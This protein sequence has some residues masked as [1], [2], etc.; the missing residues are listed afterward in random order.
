MVGTL[1]FIRHGQ[2]EWNAS[3][4]FTGWVD[5]DLTAQGVEEAQFGAELIG[6]AG[7]QFDVMY[8]SVLKRAIKTG[9]M[10]LNGTNQ[11]FIP[12]VKT[13][14]LNERMYGALQGLNKVATVEE[15][16][17]PQVLIWRR[18]FDVP[19]PEIDVSSEYWPGH[20]VQK[21]GNL[22]LKDIPRTECLK[23]VIE[24]VVPFW[25][26]EI[27]RDLR[28]GKNVLVAAHGN[29][30]RA[31]C[32]Y[33]D[34]IPD[35]VI[36]SLEIP[37]GIPLV[38][39][40]D[41]DLNPIPSDRSVAPLN[42]YFL[43]SAEEL[44]ERQEAVKNQLNAKPVATE[45]ESAGAQNAN[46]LY[47]LNVR[48]RCECIEMIANYVGFPYEKETIPVNDGFKEWGTVKPT[49]PNGQVPALRKIDGT[50]MG[51]SVDIAMYVAN[52]GTG[53]ELLMDEAQQE[54]LK[55]SQN[56]PL[57]SANPIVNIFAMDD[58]QTQVK[59]QAWTEQALPVWKE[60]EERLVSSGGPFL[61][62]TEPGVGDLGLLHCF[63][64]AQIANPEI[65]ADFGEEFTTWVESTKTLPGVAD[66]MAS[67]PRLGQQVVGKP[68]SASYGS[69]TAMEL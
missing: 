44:K 62:G 12:V 27:M 24:R 36:P 8:T 20:E 68:G 6:Q 59:I 33:L 51:E 66:Y 30:I 31:M 42:G 40:L 34:N 43:I 17:K 7:L 56:K 69:T 3:G 38:Y 57:A 64:V 60:I 67:R 35:D 29:S 10:V 25:E 23:D 15:H 22:A 9:Q 18:S 16:G 14:R 55:M 61:A 54:F 48:A 37:T 26:S 21:Y 32:K 49:M 19:P 45:N 5:V 39:E 52:N 58:E 4:Q 63:D 53:P 2:S 46:T 11:H 47:Y 1:V 13:W 41:E 50:L 65:F 28:E